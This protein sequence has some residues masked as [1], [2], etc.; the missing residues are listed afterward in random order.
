MLDN[1]GQVN[2]VEAFLAILLL[3]SALSIA[4]LF[5]PS[6]DND[7]HNSLV[8]VGMQVLT[9]ADVEGELGRLI[10]KGNWTTLEE[11]LNALLPLGTTYNL[12]VYDVTMQPLNDIPISNGMLPSQEVA[13]VQYPC[14]SPSLQTRCYL[15]RL[16]LA[17]AR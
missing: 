6:T 13:S 3:F 9:A 16:Q 12:T 2:T 4:A 7:D 1:K 10:D 17:R 11:T 5:S 15:L 8:N 14:V